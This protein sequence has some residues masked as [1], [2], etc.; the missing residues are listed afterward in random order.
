MWLTNFSG[1]GDRM[2]FASS[3]QHASVCHGSSDFCHQS[4]PYMQ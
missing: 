2:A 3:M 4:W 1:S